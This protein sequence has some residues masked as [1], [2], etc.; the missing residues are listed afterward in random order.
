MTEPT[1]EPGDNWEDFLKR[2]IIERCSEELAVAVCTEFEKDEKKGRIS[3][4]W[5]HINCAEKHLE[6]DAME[7]NW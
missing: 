3:E 6:R 1:L 2:T 5:Y 4:L 7:I